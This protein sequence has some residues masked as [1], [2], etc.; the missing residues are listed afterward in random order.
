[1]IYLSHSASNCQWPGQ[2]D[3]ATNGE[4]EIDNEVLT[5]DN[6]DRQV[7]Q[8]DSCKPRSLNWNAKEGNED[9]DI[10]KPNQREYSSIDKPNA[11]S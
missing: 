1:M 11:V 4:D 5:Y 10:C 9:C 6:G 7:N 3:G 2:G 8:R